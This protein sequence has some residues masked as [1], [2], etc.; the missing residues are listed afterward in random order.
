[1]LGSFSIISVL[2]QA[3]VIAEHKK[4]LIISMIR[5]RIPNAMHNHKSQEGCIEPSSQSS[6][7][8]GASLGSSTNTLVAAI[9]IPS[10][11]SKA[12]VCPPSAQDVSG[13]VPLQTP[14]S[15]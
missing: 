10:S 5:K 3:Q 15:H 8:N 1:M 6:C 11:V 7:T 13:Q 12:F 2:A 14:T 4:M 9:K